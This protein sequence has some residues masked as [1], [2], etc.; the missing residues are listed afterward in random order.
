MSWI[1][2]L[3]RVVVG[4][5][6]VGSNAFFVMAEFSL[7][8]LRQHDRDELG[9]DPRLARAWDM[10]EELEIYLTGCQLGISASSILLGIVAEP[11]VTRMFEPVFSAVGI[12]GSGAHVTSVVLAVL[13]INLIHKIWG[14]QAP[15]Y[16]GVE[17]PIRLARHTA[18]PLYWWTQV[19]K[20][21]ILFGDGAAKWTLSLFGVEIERSWL[22]AEEEGGDGENR[23]GPI[24]SVTQLRGR[25]KKVLA[26][27]PV[28]GE[29]RR[30]ILAA[31][32]IGEI[33]VR[34][35]M[36]PKDEIVALSTTRSNEENL[37]RVRETK[38]SR[39]PLVGESLEDFRGIVYVP[40]IFRKLPQIQ[41]GE[42][43]FEDVATEPLVLS[44]GE[45]VARVI[46]R[47]Q[48]ERHELALVRETDAEGGGDAGPIV[49]LVTAT[50]AFEAIA[51]QLEDPYD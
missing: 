26:E 6:L 44:A 8:R 7:T 1:E 13:V 14:E 5:L 50:D 42:A 18:K 45:P 9:D 51:G 33:P 3:V 21:L 12:G 30:E 40:A 11:A 48:E 15:T 38:F 4:L 23:Q 17:E 46:D 35:V 19:T 27:S 41:D 20:P 25:M 49:G 10:T 16:W 39:Y 2:G 22:E 47:F 24:T 29:R 32:D 36:V 43:T 28:D 34:D 31:L 37:E